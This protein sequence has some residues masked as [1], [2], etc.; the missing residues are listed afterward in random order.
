MKHKLLVAGI[1]IFSLVFFFLFGISIVHAG[2]SVSE[3]LITEDTLWNKSGSPYVI[4]GDVTVADGAT[5]TIQAGVEVHGVPGEDY[6]PGISVA[7][8]RLIIEGS[9]KSPVILSNVGSIQVRE[10]EADISFAEMTGGEGFSFESSQVRIAT[11]TITGTPQAVRSKDSEVIIMDS[12][13]EH[14]T[15]AIRVEPHQVFQVNSSMSHFGIG[16]L[17]NAL[18]AIPLASSSMVVIHSILTGNTRTAIENLSEYSVLATGNWWGSREGPVR[19]GANRLTGNIEYD[20]WLVSEPDLTPQIQEVTCCSSVLFIPGLQGS[21]LYN[22]TEQLWP[23]HNNG[24]VSPLFLDKNG[25]STGPSIYAGLP[26]DAAYRVKDIYIS[27]LSSLSSLKTED[28]IAGWSVF[29]YDWRKPISEVVAGKNVHRWAINGVEQATSTKTLIETVEELAAESR[30]GKVSIV[31]HSNGGLVAKY[32]VKI[33][34][35]L[36]KDSLIDQLISVAVPYV[37]TPRA[38]SALL[39]GDGQELGF[40]ALLNPTVARQLG[41]NMASAYSLLPSVEYFK[42]VLTPTIAFASSTVDDLNEGLYSQKISSASEQRSFILDSLRGRATSTVADI[43][44]PLKGNGLLMNAADILHSIIDPYTWPEHIIRYAI[45]GWNVATTKAIE[46][47]NKHVC[48][49]ETVS[50]VCGE[51]IAH[52]ELTTNLGDGTVISPSAAFNSGQIISLDL[53]KEERI[54]GEDYS[55]GDILEASTTRKIIRDILSGSAAGLPRESS[56]GDRFALPP[57]ASWG[58]PIYTG[59]NSLVVST[60]SPVE[61]HIYDSKGNHTGITETE[62]PAVEKGLYTF[63]ESNIPGSDFKLSGSHD[64]PE[65]YIY[66]P[67][68]S[69]ETYSIVVK[70]TDVGSATL[71]IERINEEATLESIEFV[72]PVTPVSLASTSI[73]RSASS[74]A[75]ISSSTLPVRLDIDGNGSTDAILKVGS[76]FDPL[77]NIK[78]IRTTVSTLLG[79]SK[80]ADT[81]DKRLVRIERL[82]E[83]G[84]LT[85]AKN[86][87]TKV[88]KKVGHINPKKLSPTDKEHIL[89]LIESMIAQFE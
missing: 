32:L 84:K 10:G 50:M 65:T 26:I 51:G 85:K 74:T 17:G 25:S 4:Q 19:T 81:L 53:K 49:R 38:V 8:S 3:T 45:V 2:T 60:H 78:L 59:S 42:R 40:G 24:D 64:D 82:I 73:T 21:R 56:I 75:S 12:R 30:T 77:L 88:G 14:N 62:L 54:S 11:S 79:P 31:A 83:K 87:A 35:D 72:M 47:E 48:H 76:G 34:A 69:G 61:L 44:T 57:S 18:Q 68:G 52:K 1:V 36:G 33:L 55:H 9:P 37:G 58:E 89:G 43:L 5:L 20:P 27:F 41:S 29:G 13:I 6:I 28:R 7:N 39:H 66:L 22:D 23:P 80:R 15:R 71:Q 46:Y 70:G 86:V 67:E 16:G 63:Y